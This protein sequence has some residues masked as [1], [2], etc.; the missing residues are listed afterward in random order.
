MTKKANKSYTLEFKQSSAK[1]A[2]ESDQP[3]AQTA[4]NLGV[5]ETTLYG[6]VT[7]YAPK[8]KQ[9]TIVKSEAEQELQQLRKENA[10]LKQERDILKKAMAYFAAEA[11]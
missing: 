4:K 5:N 6:W 1:L 3:I 9:K 10:R 7:K 11:V 2:V 8:P